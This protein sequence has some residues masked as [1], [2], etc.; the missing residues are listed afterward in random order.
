MASILD[1]VKAQP[2]RR[3]AIGGIGRVPISYGELAA[4]AAQTV[5]E[6][7]ETGIGRGDRVAVILPNGPELATAFLSIAAGASVAPLN[8]VFR[9]EEFETYL[10]D[11]AVKAVVVEKADSSI[12]ATVAERLNIPVLELESDTRQPAGWFRFHDI[13]QSKGSAQRG[14]LSEPGDEALALHTSGT[15]SRPKVVP[16]THQNLVHSTEN[17]QAVLQLC[18]DDLG[19]NIMPLFHIHGLVASLL[20]SIMAGAQV[21]CAPPFDALKF[22]R[23]LAEGKPTWYTAVPTM[24]QAILA[25]AAHNQAVVRTTR[26]RFVRSCSAALPSK[27]TDNLER[28]FN[29]PAI[30]AYGMTEAAHQISCNPLPPVQRK[31]GTVGLPAGTE[32]AILDDQQ[33]F[34]DHNQIGEI[35]IRGPNVFAGYANN[36]EAN[37]SAF[38]DGWFRTGD[39]GFLAPDGYLTV[40]GRLKEIIIRGGEKIAPREIDEVLLA[41]PA[42]DQAVAFSI[43]NPTLGEEVGAVVVLKEGACANEREIREFVAARLAKFKVPQCVL[44]RDHLPK[45]ATGKLQRIGLAQKLGLH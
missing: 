43:P 33:R 8:P 3:P 6:L 17:I 29:C 15:T 37:A 21:V 42:V 13:R 7:N 18:P 34:A 28:L 36:T 16:L 23:W 39:L 31:I 20:V 19:L 27:V 38:I 2:V 5:R 4:L 12:A 40:T 25:R 22:Y 41:H 45:S 14:G 10:S 30:E 32:V 9:E 26:L 44:F 35:V 1:L 11:L 24:H